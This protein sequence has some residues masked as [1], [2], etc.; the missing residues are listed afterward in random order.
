MDK[1]PLKDPFMSTVGTQ[2]VVTQLTPILAQ[3]RY[4][5]CWEVNIDMQEVDEQEPAPQ[6]SKKV[7]DWKF[8]WLNSPTNVHIY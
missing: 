4:P 5:R 1:L 3:L 8:Q 2:V 6:A 7:I